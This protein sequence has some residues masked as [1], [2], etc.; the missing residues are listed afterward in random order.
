M[1]EGI[2]LLVVRELTGGLYFGEPRGQAIV[3]GAP[4]GAQHDGVRRGR[5]SR[6]SRASR[7]RP[8]AGAAREVTHVHKANVLEV[9]QLWVQVVEEVA[10]DFPD[11]ELR[12]Q[13]V[14]SMA[15][16]LAARAAPPTT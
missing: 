11:V 7:S 8:R 12:H 13:L 14:D 6:A 9:S 16:L 10:K 3:D 5:R 15:M 1:V 2:D 4:R